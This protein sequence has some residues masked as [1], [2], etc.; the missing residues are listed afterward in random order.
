MRLLAGA[1]EIFKSFAKRGILIQRLYTQSSTPDGIR[2][3]RG[4]GFEDVTSPP[5]KVPRQ[6]IL[7]LETSNSPFAKEYRDILKRHTAV[8]LNSKPV[9]K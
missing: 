1:I 2:L 7:D 5:N 3:C 6:F 8:T 4:L 9:A